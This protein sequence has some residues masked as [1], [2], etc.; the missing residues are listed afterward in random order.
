MSE[1]E[2]PGELRAYNLA[3]EGMPKWLILGFSL[4]G[5]LTAVA[6]AWVFLADRPALTEQASGQIAAVRE[7]GSPATVAPAAQP[8]EPLHASASPPSIPTAESDHSKSLM[9][10]GPGAPQRADGRP[11]EL[12]ADQATP[13]NAPSPAMLYDCPQPVTIL[14]E[15]NSARPLGADLGGRVAPLRARLVSHPGA[16]LLIEGHADST[17]VEQL[18]LILSY[19]RA[20]AL[21]D[22]LRESGVASEQLIVRAAGQLQPIAGL[23]GSAPPNRRVTLQIEGSENCRA[24]STGSQPR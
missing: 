16:R 23:P 12:S 1:T 5:L 10:P 4:I 2:G 18:N 6:A 9:Q 21:S 20:K 14:F 15:S 22:F 3:G 8:D 13:A 24:S 19:Q 11:A 7:G 17:G